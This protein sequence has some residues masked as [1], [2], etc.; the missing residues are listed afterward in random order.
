MINIAY[1]YWLHLDCHIDPYTQGYIGY[2]ESIHTR[3]NT[4]CSELRRFK[5]CNKVLQE[6]YIC[7]VG[8]LFKS[9]IFKGTKQDCLALEYKLRPTFNIGWNIDA[10]GNGRTYPDID[11]EL[12]ILEQS[13]L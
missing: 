1:L 2:T 4:H 7:N 10:G 8:H 13:K 12:F 3:L 9:V 5:H 11:K 6:A